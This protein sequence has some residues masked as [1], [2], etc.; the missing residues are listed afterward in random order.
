LRR[1]DLFTVV[2]E[3]FQ[4]DT[5][6]YADWLLP[7]TTQLEHWDIHASYGHLYVTLNQPAIEPIGESLPNSE[8]FRRLAARMKLPDADFWDSDL[9]LIRQALSSG[10]PSL[11]GITLEGLME[12]GY[13]RLNVPKPFA[14]LADPKNLQTPSGRIDFFSPALEQL[15]FSGFPDFVPPAE[16]TQ[17][18]ESPYPLALL[19]PPEHQFLNST[20]VNVEALAKAAG[21]P[22][23]LLNPAD[24]ARRGVTDGDFVHT[25]NDRGGFVA[26]AVVTE[27]VMPGV[28]VSYG[29]RWAR[30][31]P[32]G[33]TVNDTTSQRETDLG[34]GAV[35]YDNAVQ[36]ELASQ[37]QNESD[38][39]ES[40]LP[41]TAG[42]AL[43]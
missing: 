11:D 8:I 43:G 29:V 12:T 14:P 23:L 39:A 28:A 9:D 40:T 5:A 32:E 35:F 33:K 16:L 27:D 41:A 4:T 25:W 19:S 10:H 37:R 7:A 17:D 31:S 26:S 38:P 3:H 1:D 21:G 30:S 24:A 13:A 36:V 6:D 22:K 34:H 20:F 2:L 15:G 18:H 42:S